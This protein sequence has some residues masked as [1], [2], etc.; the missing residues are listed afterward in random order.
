[1]A[2]QDKHLLRLRS[3]L[4]PTRISQDLRL[5]IERMRKCPNLLNDMFSLCISCVYDHCWLLIRYV[6]FYEATNLLKHID[7]QLPEILFPTPNLHT[8]II[9]TKIAW[10]KLSGKFPMGQGI[11]PLNI[12]ILLESNPLKSI[13]LVRKVPVCRSMG[14][15]SLGSVGHLLDTS[16]SSMYSAS[17]CNRHAMRYRPLPTCVLKMNLRI[18]ST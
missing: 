16:V 13:I 4:T 8:K 14:S 11:P 15:R 1:M 9:P 3:A 7:G 5:T 10:L 12:K 18:G 2:H 6:S 17:L